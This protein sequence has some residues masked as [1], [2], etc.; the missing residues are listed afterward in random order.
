MYLADNGLEC[1]QP[2]VFQQLQ[3]KRWKP[4]MHSS[5]FTIKWPDKNDTGFLDEDEEFRWLHELR[6]LLFTYRTPQPPEVLTGINAFNHL[7][8]IVKVIGDDPSDQ[9]CAAKYVVGDNIK[10]GF[11]LS[12]WPEPSEEQLSYMASS[13]LM[14]QEEGTMPPGHELIFFTCDEDRAPWVC[15]KP[16]TAQPD[17]SFQPA[18]TAAA[19]G[20]KAA[21]ASTV[22]AASAQST[23]KSSV[24]TAARA[25]GVPAGHRKQAA[26]T[27]QAGH[28]GPTAS[29]SSPAS[30]ASS[31]GKSSTRRKQ[32]AGNAALLA[33][34]MSFIEHANPGTHDAPQADE[35]P[36]WKS[37]QP[38]E[39]QANNDVH[40]PP[41]R[42][43]AWKPSMDFGAHLRS[44]E[45]PAHEVHSD[46]DD[47]LS[48]AFAD[49]STPHS[50]AEREDAAKRAEQAAAA[51][52]LEEEQ[53]KLAAA[54]AVSAKVHGNH[55]KKGKG[56][57]TAS[58]R[59]AGQ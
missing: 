41:A 24:A 21:A 37:C 20:R 31:A 25:A 57:R 35:H 14:M 34:L 9:Y 45:G 58:K 1:L 5:S 22:P 17:S 15:P 46:D 13:L 23:L 47:V 48:V 42:N 4:Q 2:A 28:A 19:P 38:S 36:H 43:K 16:A 56:K 10:M 30:A 52:I 11:A 54:K 27:K 29:R 40:G 3:L 8:A 32:A 12:S 39:D 55:A 44:W 6:C 33:E 18:S 50:M 53:D 51:L 26:S 59:A 49:T 7:A